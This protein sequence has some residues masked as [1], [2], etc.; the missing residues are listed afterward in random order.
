MAVTSIAWRRPRRTAAPE[1]PASGPRA[2][3][4]AWGLLLAAAC[5]ASAQCSWHDAP[6]LPSGGPAARL[7]LA[8]RETAL[9]AADGALSEAEAFADFPLG[10]GHAS[11]RW[12]F[13]ILSLPAATGA[14]LGDPSLELGYRAQ[15]A[16]WTL[17]IQARFSAPLGD[18]GAGLGSDAFG[19]A[20]YLS[21]A[22]A[23]GGWAAGAWAG[24]RGMV[25]GRAGA[26]AHAHAGASLADA[27]ALAHPH[28][29]CEWAYRAAAARV[30]GR[31]E[32]SLALD[33][34][35][36]LGRAMGVPGR[37]FLEGE[38]SLR[39]RIGT[40]EWKPSLRWPMSPERRLEIS[41]GLSAARAW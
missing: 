12:P 11:L 33:G 34:A 14:G 7:G 40:A 37:D 28:S 31:T 8:W 32:A 24:I 19:A 35:H 26:H 9:S 27:Y 18:A 38:A 22:W 6:A 1:R 23:R 5:A 39:F 13:A 41:A 4:T 3:R 29:D 2:A 20:G 36:V 25:G 17:G 10:D 30:W 21:A 15:A 16:A